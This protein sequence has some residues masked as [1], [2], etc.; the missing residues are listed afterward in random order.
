MNLINCLTKKTIQGFIFIF[1]LLLNPLPAAEAQEE[2][3]F[4]GV[5]TVQF[6][7]EISGKFNRQ[8]AWDVNL[9]NAPGASFQSRPKDMEI[10]QETL[11]LLNRQTQNIF[12]AV[13]SSYQIKHIT[14]NKKDSKK[15][16][17][18]AKPIFTDD[19][20]RYFRIEVVIAG[21]NGLGGHYGGLDVQ[22]YFKSLHRNTGIVYGYSFRTLK[23]G[24]SNEE[25]LDELRSVFS[26]QLKESYNDWKGSLQKELKSPRRY[27]LLH[28]DVNELSPKQQK[29]IRKELF[30]CFYNRADSLGYID[31]KNFYYQ[32]FYRL[33]NPE[34]G[35]TE[36]SYITDYAE[37]LQF[38]M[39]SSAKYP[40]SLWKT[41]M[42]NYRA[43]FKI[44]STHKL[45][46]IG[47]RK[48]E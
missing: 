26:D 27:L 6:Y 24:R 40:C 41:P 1:I 15:F 30:P 48:P 10:A 9:V 32:I 18:R 13:L 43:T 19:G 42:E 33:K 2:Q 17:E 12:S 5:D 8:S 45:I 25:T 14:Q 23:L 22:L 4:N 16:R 7:I 28:F 36:E 39:G 35:E 44:D 11:D 3:L 46:T 29:F 20:D 31:L 34:Q 47:W 21:D 38:S 37:L